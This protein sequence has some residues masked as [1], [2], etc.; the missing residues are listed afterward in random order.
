[1]TLLHLGNYFWDLLRM[2][3]VIWALLLVLGMVADRAEACECPSSGPPCQNYFQVDAIFLGTVQT[4]SPLEGTRDLRRLVVF[5]MD[6]AFRGVDGVTAEVAT[7]MGGGDCGY[8]FRVGERYIVYAFRTRD[9]SRLA[10][11]ICSRT[12]PAAGAVEDLKFIEGLPTTGAGARVYGAITHW[13]RDL[14]TGE[15]RNYGPVPSVRVTLHGPSGTQETR[16]DGAGGYSIQGLAPGRYELDVTPPTPFST[17]YLHLKIELRDSRACAVEDFGVRYDGRIR[18][19]ALDAE[20]TPAADITI[21]AMSAE[22]VESGGN[23]ETLSAKTDS[24]GHF[25]F[26]EVPPGRYVVGASLSRGI[27]RDGLFPRTFYPG[28][29]AASGATVVSITNGNQERLEP[30][31]VPPPRHRR[32]LAGVVVWPDGRLVSG[33]FVSLSDG[34]AV[35]R[36]V[37]VGIKTDADGRFTFLVYDGLSYSALASYT[38]PDDPRHRQAGVRSEPF[39]ASPALGPMKLVL[40][41]PPDR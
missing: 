29:A 21:Q 25:E 9:G 19:V 38:I 36:Q 18:G 12:R 3:H 28:S 6:R 35:W 39:V 22:R 30:F 33:A 1:M 16:T 7:G 14:A 37:A 17:K 40:V 2:K 24:A 20:G 13:E 23:V 5:T 10:A 31:R 26:A 41:Q 8:P 34:L 15:S 11:S 4:I 27:E 32:E